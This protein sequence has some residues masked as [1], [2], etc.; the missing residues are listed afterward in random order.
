M[1]AKRGARWGPLRGE[2]AEM[3]QLAAKL[4]ELA[5]QYE[6]PLRTLEK[7][8]PYTRSTI[9][10]R[11]SGASRPDWDFV[12]R[13]VAACVGA[14]LGA[15]QL[16]L[17]RLRPIW[18]AADPANARPRATVMPATSDGLVSGTAAL[19]RHA[20]GVELALNTNTRYIAGLSAALVQLNEIINQLTGERDALQRQVAEQAMRHAMRQAELAQHEL[21]ATQL[22][23]EEAVGAQS[24]TQDLLAEAMRQRAEAQRLKN[25]AQEQLE[26]AI[27]RIADLD[28]MAATETASETSPEVRLVVDPDLQ[29]VDA[30]LR[31]ADDALHQ[32]ADRLQRL[33]SAG[34]SGERPPD[35][36]ATS[37]D[38]HPQLQRQPEIWVGVPPR[39]RRFTGR[40][41]LL[42][43]I[44]SGVTH[45]GFQ[46]LT[47]IAGVGKTQ[48]VTEYAY[49][50]KGDYDAVWWIFADQ[51][52]IV[53]SSLASLAPSLDVSLANVSDLA[54][55]AGVVLDALRRGRPYDRWL[56]IFDNANDPDYLTDV[57]PID[58]GHVLVTTRDATWSRVTDTLAVD[59][60]SRSESVA[61]LNRR[62]PDGGL[63]PAA[64]DRLADSVGDLPLALEQMVALVAET[65]MTV[66]ENLGL[67]ADHGVRL[68]SQAKSAAYP[69]A[70]SAVWQLSVISLEEEHPGAMDLLRCCAML[71]PEQVPLAVFDRRPGLSMRLSALLADRIEVTRAIRQLVSRGLARVGTADRTIQVHRLTQAFIRD[72]LEAGSEGWVRHDVHLLLAGY[73]IWHPEDLTAWPLFAAVVPHI[74]VAGVTECDA[75]ESRE[76]ILRVARYL[77]VSG[78]R[79]TVLEWLDAVVD[80]WVPRMGDDDSYVTAL[81]RER[82]MLLRTTDD[83]GDANG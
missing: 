16:W 34:L 51:S 6:R 55:A 1:A 75:A 19:Q 32:E 52:D 70:G 78:D 23:L 48:L 65:G 61:F 28:A 57:I 17:S 76:L 53:W 77:R 9:S 21:A 79:A 2:F 71:G 54:G 5:D 50:H 62:M 15:R 42:D 63:S 14:D 18:E 8:L 13:L 47:G 35:K 45:V 43:E 3:R 67:L 72:T 36:P 59:V 58:A 31:R 49:R 40:E 33:G 56:L 80:M 12:E 26:H 83:A 82:T 74:R 68:F 44:R 69:L 39:N 30:L 22:R 7:F 27:R 41:A 29:G 4:R 11:L 38:T 10:E 73:V 81:M 60:F 66:S 24:K 25:E 20:A 64:A 37:P 46:V